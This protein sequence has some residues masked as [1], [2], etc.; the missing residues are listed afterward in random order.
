MH[1]AGHLSVLKLGVQ[2]LPRTRPIFLFGLKFQQ[3]VAGL[4]VFGLKRECFFGQLQRSVRVT[5]GQFLFHDAT[6]ADK[7][8]RFIGNQFAIGLFGLTAVTGHFGGLR[9]QQIG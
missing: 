6:Y 8:S 2:C 9:Y 4:F 3:H 5:F 7:P 1:I